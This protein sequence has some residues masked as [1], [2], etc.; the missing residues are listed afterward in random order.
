MITPGSWHAF[1]T[2]FMA[3]HRTRGEHVPAPTESAPVR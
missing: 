1:T 2:A 3:W